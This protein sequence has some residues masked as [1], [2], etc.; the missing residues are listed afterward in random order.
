[1]DAAVTDSLPDAESY[2]KQ[3]GRSVYTDYVAANRIRSLFEISFMRENNRERATLAGRLCDSLRAAMSDVD[4]EALERWKDPALH[5]ATDRPLTYV[6][7]VYRMQSGDYETAVE[8]FANAR[9][10]VPTV[11]LWRLE[12]TWLLL[13]CRRHLMSEP[14]AE[15]LRLCREAIAIGELLNR[16]GDQQSPDVMRYLGLSYHLAGDYPE[17][18]RCLE[19]AFALAG[20]A[21]DDREPVAA[22]ADCY[23]KTGRSEEAR[24]LLD[25][26]AETFPSMHP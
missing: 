18:T 20:G 16:L 7:G 21:G 5:G 4:R 10:D 2:A 9:A 26:A 25:A 22:L 17:A 1:V 24:R 23:L 6:V 13:E 11:S 19:R 12:L 8:L 15:D 14:Q 3:L